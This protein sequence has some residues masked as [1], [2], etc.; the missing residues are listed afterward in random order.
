MMC[1]MGCPPSV[2]VKSLSGLPHL[3][4]SIAAWSPSAVARA[5]AAALAATAFCALV[6][7]DGVGA[8]GPL[9]SIIANSPHAAISPINHAS[10]LTARLVKR[11]PHLGHILA[12]SATS[13]P[14]LH[15]RIRVSRTFKSRIIVI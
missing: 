5:L 6:G 7:V 2:L 1:R 10:I 14:Q 11:C 9:D 13:F 8:E 15:F 4:M 12:L 3:P